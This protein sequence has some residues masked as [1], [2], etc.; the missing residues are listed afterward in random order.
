VLIREN[1]PKGSVD[2]RIEELI[3]KA[4]IKNIPVASLIHAY[5]LDQNILTIKRSQV[6][7]LLQVKQSWSSGGWAGAAGRPG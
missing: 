6:E 4:R 7:A 2:E 3:Q 1:L 5:S